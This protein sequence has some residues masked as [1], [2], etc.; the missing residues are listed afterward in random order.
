[1]AASFNTALKALRMVHFGNMLK[2]SSK[3]VVFLGIDCSKSKLP[4][5]KENPFLYA[6]LRKLSPHLDTVQNNSNQNL[7]PLSPAPNSISK[8]LSLQLA[9]GSKSS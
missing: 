3:T 9:S 4:V 2:P 5:R 6:M 7:N 1:M 8:S